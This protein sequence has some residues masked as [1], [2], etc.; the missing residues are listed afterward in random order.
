M[1]FLICLILNCLFCFIEALMFQCVNILYPI[2]HFDVSITIT[3]E[4]SL[5]I[6]FLFRVIYLFLFYY[7]FKKYINVIFVI[8]ILSYWLN[9]SSFFPNRF[10]VY[11]SVSIILY[12][13]YVI[14]QNYLLR[15]YLK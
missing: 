6:G 1:M 14:L 10:M 8:I 9:V 2:N 4:C 13:I 11:L 5:F 12:F 7:S 15:K 3:I